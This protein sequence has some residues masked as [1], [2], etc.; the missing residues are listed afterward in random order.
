MIIGKVAGTVVATRKSENLVGMKFLVVQKYKMDGTPSADYVVA[1]DAVGA[2]AEEMVMV[3]T[4]SSARLTS[5]TEGKPTDA[6]II[7][8]IDTI[9]LREPVGPVASAK[10][11]ADKD[12]KKTPR[13]SRRNEK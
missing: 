10:P 13:S 4:G 8:I 3:V 11:A 12:G 5:R 9:Q 2:G 7:G 1:L 6:T